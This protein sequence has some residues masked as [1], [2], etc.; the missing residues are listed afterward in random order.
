MTYILSIIISITAI[1]FALLINEV[2]GVG[3]YDFNYEVF[4]DILS[5]KQGNAII[6]CAR[7]FNTMTIILMVITNISWFITAT[8]QQKKRRG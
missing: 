5:G 8:L 1:I 7:S 2:L 3:I 6:A 4:H